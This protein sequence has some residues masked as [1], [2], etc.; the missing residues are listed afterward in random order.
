MD[1]RFFLLRRTNLNSTISVRG[2]LVKVTIPS[3]RWICE[4]PDLKNIKS[5]A[6]SDS[7]NQGSVCNSTCRRHHK[8]RDPQNIKEILDILPGDFGPNRL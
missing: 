4:T 8:V 5:I 1:P 3:F 6:C 2:S 7:F